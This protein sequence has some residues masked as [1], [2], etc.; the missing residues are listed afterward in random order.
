MT[1]IYVCDFAYLVMKKKS[2]DVYLLCL[3]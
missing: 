3:V 2:T 1:V